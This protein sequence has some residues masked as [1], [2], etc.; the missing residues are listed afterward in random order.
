MIYLDST[1]I[2]LQAILGGAVG[3]SQP[4]VHVFFYDVP[5]QQKMGNEDYKGAVKRTACNSANDV[6][7]CAAPVSQNTTRCIPSIAIHN[8]DNANATI[9]IKTDDGSTE[10]ILFKATLATL[11]CATY[12][13]GL[14][15]QCY[16]AA[17]A[18]K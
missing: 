16:T 12:E 10:Y 4:E 9:T 7:I 8:K 11:E 14:G 18:R 17:G 15:W 2:S 13:D 5:A 6:T 3:A 1:L